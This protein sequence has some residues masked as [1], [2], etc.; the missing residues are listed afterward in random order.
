M[1]GFLVYLRRRIY[2]ESCCYIIADPEGEGVRKH[3]K[4]GNEKEN[5]NLNYSI[6]PVFTI[7]CVQRRVM[8]NNFIEISYFY[9]SFNSET[10]LHVSRALSKN[11]NNNNND[12]KNN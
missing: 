7:L 5:K 6:N 1:F 11:N 2:K 9:V 4:K 10:E 8:K 12:N 3:T